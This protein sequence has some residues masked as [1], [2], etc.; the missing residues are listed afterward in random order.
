MATRVRRS[1]T[2]LFSPPRRTALTFLSTL[3]VLFLVI[4]ILMFGLAQSQGA[5][6]LPY[7]AYL[8]GS[9][10]AFCLALGLGGMMDALSRS[11]YAWR[12]TDL[13]V[14]LGLAEWKIP[15]QAIEWVRPA[16]ELAFPFKVPVLH[17]PGLIV[18]E[19]EDTNLGRVHFLATQSRGLVLVGTPDRVFALSPADVPGFMSSYSQINGESAFLG[20]G[21]LPVRLTRPHVHEDRY[22]RGLLSAAGILGVALL[23]LCVALVPGRASVSLGFDA[24][25][26]PLEAFP[27]NRLL[28]LPWF[29]SVGALLDLSAGFFLFWR[30]NPRREMAY[31]L[32]STASL[33]AFLLLLA[34]LLWIL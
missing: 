4:A 14:R 28:L 19:R 8:L 21:P 1:A 25:G 31:F 9:A 23:V 7:G 10:V 30:P 29:N 12:G 17:W 15:A 2:L 13:I 3:L 27:A 22:G 32:W 20:E 24:N 16:D 34:V 18:A 6:I 26:N 5:G 11:T 33:L